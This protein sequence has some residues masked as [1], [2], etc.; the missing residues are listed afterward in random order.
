MKDIV[1][2]WSATPRVLI[3]QNKRNKQK[4]NKTKQ[5]KTKQNK[6]K[7]NKTKQNKKKNNACMDLNLVCIGY[8]SKIK[9][10]KKVNRLILI[11]Y[12]YITFVIHN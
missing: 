6:P 11:Y 10:I 12:Y 9:I 7:Q 8:L 5:N 3:K 1:Q 2:T 4:Q